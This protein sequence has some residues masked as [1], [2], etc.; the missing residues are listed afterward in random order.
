MII[1]PKTKVIPDLRILK[2]NEVWCQIECNEGIARELHEDFSFQTKGYQFGKKKGWDGRIHLFNLRT[3]TIYI[4]LLDKV[5]R[6]AYAKHYTHDWVEF[7]YPFHVHWTEWVNALGLPKEMNGRPFEVRED[8]HFI[9]KQCIAQRRSI[10]ISPTGSGKSLIA[11]LLTRYYNK[12]TLIIVP[13]INLVNQLYS[14]FKDYGFDSDQMVHR[15]YSYDGMEP[16]TSKP[17]TIST[18]QSMLDMPTS[19]F[20]DFEVVVGDEA[21]GFK[22]KSLRTIMERLINTPYRFA[23]TA[24]LANQDREVDELVIEGLFG[25]QVLGKSTQDLMQ[26]GHLAEIEIYCIILQY[27]QK[28]RKA[29]K[30]AQIT[31]ETDFLVGHKGRQK[32]I[33]NLACSLKGATFILFRLV[34]KH[35][36]G[37]Y[38]SIKEFK[39]EKA[40]LVYGETEAEV[41]EA[42]R[43]TANVDNNT[44]VVASYGVFSGG[45]NV[46]NLKNAIMASN[47]KAKTKV[48]QSIGRTIR[49]T[50]TKDKA[51]IFDIVDDLSVGNWQNYSLRH[52]TERLKLYYR[53]FLDM[54]IKI[55]MVPL[56]EPIEEGTN[57][58]G[59]KSKKLYQQS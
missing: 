52:F 10:I 55:V 19:F 24:T 29:L 6:W 17:V 8:Q 4:G 48:L 44:T 18:W 23:M 22:A 40:H 53:E 34:D 15:V 20:Q 56:E 51:M 1:G 26:E 37:I 14:D 35:G 36:K 5:I 21:H 59:K 47:Y 57:T 32:Y 58:H 13:T 7:P 2:L 46:P 50:G 39:K 31:D 27:P 28:D 25:P 54:K 38:E 42:V 41:R 43:L 49:K 30:K 45:V 12:K 16:T 3:Y 11:Y 9:V 33:R